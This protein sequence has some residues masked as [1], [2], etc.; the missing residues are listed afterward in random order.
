[1]SSSESLG[2]LRARHSC[3]YR[4]CPTTAVAARSRSPLAACHRVWLRR[5]P[6]MRVEPFRVHRSW[7]FP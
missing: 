7:P 1:M 3:V 5:L 6:T 2:K 4:C